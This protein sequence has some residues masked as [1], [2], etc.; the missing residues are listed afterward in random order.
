M[1][2]MMVSFNRPGNKPAWPRRKGFFSG[3]A[4]HF[5]PNG[6]ALRLQCLHVEINLSLLKIENPFA[7]ELAAYMGE[8]RQRVAAKRK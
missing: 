4:P 6:D 2:R 3:V 8:E 7:S 5:F 1:L